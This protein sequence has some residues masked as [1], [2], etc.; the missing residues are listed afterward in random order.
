MKSKILK[1]FETMLAV[2]WILGTCDWLP[3]SFEAL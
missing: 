1:R 2:L 3:F